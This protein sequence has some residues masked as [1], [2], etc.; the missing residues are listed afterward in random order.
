MNETNVKNKMH[1]LKYQA[2]TLSNIKSQC[3]SAKPIW[4]P[5]QNVKYEQYLEENIQVY[6]EMIQDNSALCGSELQ[7][8]ILK[9]LFTKQIADS[10]QYCSLLNFRSNGEKSL[11]SYIDCCIL[12]KSHSFNKSKVKI[13]NFDCNKR[14]LTKQKQ[15]SDAKL[16][17]KIIRKQIEWSKLHN[18]PL[19]NL[20]QYLKYPLAIALPD[21]SPNPGQKAAAG[22]F[23]SKMA[24]SAFMTFVPP[25]DCPNMV[26]IDAMFIITGAPP[27]TCIT[28]EDYAQVLYA[29]WVTYYFT[30]YP[31]VTQVAVAFD[32]QSDSI[33]M[34]PKQFERKR[35]D[36]ASAFKETMQMINK[37]SKLPTKWMVF[38]KNRQN[39]QL[40][41]NFICSCFC[42]L[43]VTHL[44]SGQSLIISGGFPETGTTVLVNNG[45]FSTVPSLGHN[46]EEGDTLVCFLATQSTGQNVLIYSPDNDTY[47]IG[48]SATSQ[49]HEKK[50]IMQLKSNKDNKN[51]VN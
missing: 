28:F 31:S 10:L 48:F 16:V 20:S 2:N 29:K 37:L 38:L 30:K 44:Q 39:K 19:S 33:L 43:G 27:S 51:F 23:F 14:G 34:T 26:V 13:I 6:L 3:A 42:E 45:Q 4:P 36:D 25:E 47:N 5:T 11:C 8:N 41:V 9:H 18:I 40:L 49:Y 22:H 12:Q 21:G 24:P 46:H 17:N 35:R 32:K 7:C 15:L 1:F 50:I